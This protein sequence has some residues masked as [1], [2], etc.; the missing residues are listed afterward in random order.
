MP[1]PLFRKK[2]IAAILKE[3]EEGLTD[4]HG[5]HEDLKKVL[6]VRDLTF[7]G[8]AAVIGTGVFT[9]IGTASFHGGPAVTLLFA[10]TAV[11]CGFAAFCYA[12][13]ASTVPVS[14]SAYTYSYVSFGELFAWIIGWDLLMEYAI[15]NIA[16]AVSWSQYFIRVLEGFHIYIPSWLAMDSV[17]AHHGYKDAVSALSKGADFN[18]LD[19]GLQHAYNAWQHA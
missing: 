2:S 12:E 1:H 9:A 17:T 16:V 11:A 7:F 15:G 18:S 4:A 10:L 19:S 14:G 3:A 6:T 8:I 5:H 13:F